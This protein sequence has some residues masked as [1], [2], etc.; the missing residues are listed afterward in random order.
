MSTPNRRAS[1]ACGSAGRC[2]LA[3]QAAKD[4]V[5]QVFAILG[6]DINNP[7][8]V[9]EF[10]MSLRF[11]DELRIAAKLA[12]E[13]KATFWNSV[14]VEVVGK[15]ILHTLLVILS[16]VGLGLLARYKGLV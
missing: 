3:D 11:S 7:K 16:L 4:A 13:A 6:V 12:A 1:D 10:R 9:E 8:D 2:D 5:K 14:S 15:G